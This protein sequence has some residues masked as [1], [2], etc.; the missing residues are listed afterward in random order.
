MKYRIRKDLI[1][2]TYRYL[3]RPV[4][5]KI[6]PEWVHDAFTFL[7]EFFGKFRITRKLI[8]GVFSYS[9][10]SLEQNVLGI[11][12][13]NPVGLSAGF[14]KD[15]RL[16]NVL[17]PIGFGAC[18]V[19]TMTDEPSSGNPK[20][21]LFR[22]PRSKGIVVYYGLKNI[23]ITKALK[24]LS[25]KKVNKIVLG[26]SIGKTNC[27]KTIGLEQ[28]IQDYFCGMQKVVDS[29][30]GDFYTINISCPNTF[31]GEPFV[32]ADRLRKLL[33][34]LKELPIEKP[35]F[36]KMPI[37]EPWE[38]FK[39]LLDVA[40]EYGIKGVVIGNLNK[41]RKDKAV[42][43]PIPDFVKGAMSGRPTKKLSDELIS[44]TYQYCG[45]RLM[46]VGVGGIFSAK[47]AY[48]K[49]K[50]GA[51]LVQLITGM[52][53]KGPQLIGVMNQELV[54]LLE[55]EGYKNITEAIGAYHKK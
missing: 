49:I 6:N 50:R 45:D 22:L 47:D 1:G 42:K 35:L 31:G 30:I 21:R 39:E 29:G 48:E 32:T 44:K 16:I 37:N 27:E 19:G 12:F 2:G 7:G 17:E 13:S 24:R 15:A 41:D 23:G 53:Y 8:H 36:L 25:R 51:T 34:K 26:L 9:H 18:E 10:P 33:E 14:D 4:L 5:F 46:I 20:P 43:D 3:I 55:K 54:E 40:L 11:Q 28:G 52:I 38:I